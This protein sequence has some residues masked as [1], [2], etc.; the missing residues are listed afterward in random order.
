MRLSILILAIAIFLNA[1]SSSG[2]ELV[3]V[4]GEVIGA[5]D[6]KVLGVTYNVSFVDGSCI[7]VFNGCDDAAADFPFNSEDSQTASTALRSLIMGTLPRPLPATY[8]GCSLT[9]QC[10]IRT[11]GVF[12]TPTTVQF[13]AVSIHSLGEPSSIPT[14]NTGPDYDDENRTMAVWTVAPQVPALAP[15]GMVMLVGLMG[16]AGWIRLRG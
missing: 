15:L 9:N 16:L 5:V 14:D 13:G 8:R 7:D 11:P 3:V 10:L 6:V 1:L 12:L 4:E 2:A